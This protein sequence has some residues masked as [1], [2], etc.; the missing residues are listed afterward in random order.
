MPVVNLFVKV[1]IIV[2]EIIEN[3]YLKNKKKCFSM[4]EGSELCIKIL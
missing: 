4:L 3:N 1:K 2:K